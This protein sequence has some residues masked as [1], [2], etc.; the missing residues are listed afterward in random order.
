MHATR[1][2]YTISKNKIIYPYTDLLLHDMGARLSDSVQE[3]DAL[4][5]EWK[6]PALWGNG[7]KIR[8]SKSYFLH[9]GRARN[10]LEAILWHGG[11]ADKSRKAFESLPEKR[12]NYLLEFVESL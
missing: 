10:I 2:S 7:K 4:G 12:R 6:T 9:D 11:E 5:Y 1:P 8:K 3:G